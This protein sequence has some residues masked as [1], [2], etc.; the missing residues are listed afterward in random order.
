MQTSLRR[1]GIR[2]T[3]KEGGLTTVVDATFECQGKA[4]SACSPRSPMLS[5]WGSPSYQ[6][7]PDYYPTGETLFACGAATN[8]GNYCNRKVESLINAAD[9]RGKG[10]SLG[11]FHQLDVLLAKQLPVLW[12]P[13]AP[14]QIS[15]ISPK[16]GGV[17]AQDA[18][19]DI[20]AATWYVKR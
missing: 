6:Y 12:M 20:N 13:N 14:I 7:S 17:G 9:A 10:T 19:G 11:R 15:A 8:D 5:Y 2:I 3:L 16:L 1:A 4:M 18:S